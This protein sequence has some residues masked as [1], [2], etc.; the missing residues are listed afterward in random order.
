MRKWQPEYTQTLKKIGL[1]R[2]VR[3]AIRL[4]YE[5]GKHNQTPYQL[6]QSVGAQP[7]NF[8][9]EAHRIAVA[10]GVWVVE[11]EGNY[12]AEVARLLVL[13]PMF[14]RHKS[15]NSPLHTQ[16][17]IQT[18]KAPN[19]GSVQPPPK[20]SVAVV[21]SLEVEKIKKALEALGEVN[22]KALQTTLAGSP[23]SEGE[24]LRVVEAAVPLAAKKTKP[25]AWIMSAL[26]NASW[27]LDILRTAPVPLQAVSSP[28][29][30]QPQ[31]DEARTAL[32]A[33]LD[34]AA[35]PAVER[36]TWC[37]PATAMLVLAACQRSWEV[38]PA[39]NQGAFAHKALTD[40]AM[41]KSIL[42]DFPAPKAPVV[43]APQPKKQTLEK[44]LLEACNWIENVLAG[45]EDEH[46]GV[47]DLLP[48]AIRG[49]ERYLEAAYELVSQVSGRLFR[50]PAW[51]S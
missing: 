4:W 41:G 44:C 22:A 11:C 28:W 7:R 12:H 49:T 21:V 27:C 20:P 17:T 10:A 3:E 51:A 36:R 18:T 43:A 35:I 14:S 47:L 29:G 6:A 26:R 38:R 46:P 13:G 8:Y 48:A 2:T 31:A 16:K 40:Q 34:P 33:T 15:R 5:S 1:G 37:D 30:T 39:R 23:L 9:G 42:R 19:L 50:P 24:A 32:A 25:I 45:Y